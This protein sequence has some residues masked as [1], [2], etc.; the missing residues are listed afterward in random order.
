MAYGNFTYIL[1]RLRNLILGY[2]SDI[3]LI[4]IHVQY[5]YCHFETRAFYPC[6]FA[7]FFRKRPLT[8]EIQPIVYGLVKYRSKRTRNET[9]S[10]AALAHEAVVSICNVPGRTLPAFPGGRGREAEQVSVV[11][12][13]SVYLSLVLSPSYQDFTFIFL[14]TSTT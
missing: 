10:R 8:F 5:V 9:C 6:N 13:R 3:V 11:H 7:C 12:V 14:T 4:R 2:K 1:Y